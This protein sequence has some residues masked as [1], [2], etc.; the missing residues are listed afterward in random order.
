MSALD[1]T[2][3]GA[4]CQSPLGKASPD[5]WVD[6]TDQEALNLGPRLV[7]EG[8]IYTVLRE[9]K[10]GR[11]IALQG[12]LGKACACRIYDRRPSVCRT[13]EPGHTNCLSARVRMGLPA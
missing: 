7:K 2:T 13:F 6:L 4:C 11:C 1:C 5:G 9:R 10:D 3:C 8:A 12:E